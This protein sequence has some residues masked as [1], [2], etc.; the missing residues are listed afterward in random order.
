MKAL[1]I[2]TLGQVVRLTGSSS[3]ERLLADI[4]SQ[5]GEVSLMIPKRIQI[6]EEMRDY[7]GKFKSVNRFKTVPRI[8]LGFQP[9]YLRTFKRMT[10]DEHFDVIVYAYSFGSFPLALL[11]PKNSK[12]IYLAH[13]FEYRYFKKMYTKMEY[14]LLGGMSR[15]RERLICGLSD[16]IISVSDDDRKGISERFG[17]SPSKIAVLQLGKEQF[18]REAPAQKDKAREGLDLP[19]N[20]KLVIFHG[21]YSHSPN[22]TAIRRIIDNIAPIVAERNPNIEFVIAGSD[23]PKLSENNVTSIGFVDDLMAFID[24]AD[25]AIIPVEIGVGVRV[26]MI[27]YMSRGLPVIATKDAMEGIDYS[28]G[29]EVVLA[30][31]DKDFVEKILKLVD[32]PTTAKSIG[33]SARE[34]AMKNFSPD[35]ARVTLEGVMRDLSVS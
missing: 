26:K 4:M 11:I 25:L 9:D 13:F 16:Y 5:M 20:K 10:R 22:R 1:L 8:P 7:L 24:A 34:Y 23:V 19:A 29:R 17:I 15:I 6:T 35:V 31:D 12:L 18:F 30:G 2:S 21:S 32:D 28:D 33:E 3:T 27:D 14:L